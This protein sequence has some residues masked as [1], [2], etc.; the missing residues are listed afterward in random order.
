MVFA[1]DNYLVRQGTA[2]LLATSDQVELLEAVADT[3]ALMASVNMHQPEAGLT[4]IRMPL[5]SPPRASTPLDRFVRGTPASAS[6]SCRSRST[7][8]RLRAV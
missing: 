1:D 2:A 3:S 6:S 5:R 4:D 7:G 8:L